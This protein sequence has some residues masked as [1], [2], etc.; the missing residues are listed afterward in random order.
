MDATRDDVTHLGKLLEG[1]DFCML[2]THGAN[3]ELHA[4]PMSTQRFAFDGTLLF[5]T[6]LASHKAE[7]IALDDRVLVSYADPHSQ[8]YVAVYGR[9]RLQRDEELIDR[10]WS[11]FYRAYWPNGKH[12]PSI[13]V[14]TVDVERADFW[15]SPGGKLTQL[16]GFAKAALGRGSAED[17]GT[18]GTVEL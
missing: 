1:I 7:D 14:L 2:A 6:D 17:M 10:L 15:E 3:G 9:A 16:V 11:P 12:D 4:R 5:L 8:T 18:Q 13:T